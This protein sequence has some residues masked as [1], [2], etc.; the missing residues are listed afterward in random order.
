M[1]LLF[2]LEFKQLAVA[3]YMVSPVGFWQLRVY[4]FVGDFT[5]VFVR[6]ELL[7]DTELGVTGLYF[8][9]PP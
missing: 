6:K 1:T 8:V 2:A 9:G 5:G 3:D 4:H 7:R